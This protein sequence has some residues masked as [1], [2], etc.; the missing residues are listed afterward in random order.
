MARG[1]WGAPG[2]GSCFRLTLPRHPGIPI[3]SSPGPL[4]PSSVTAPKQIASGTMRT[5]DGGA[6]L[7]SGYPSTI[8]TKKATNA[9]PP[10]LEGEAV[11]RPRSDE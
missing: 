4:Q 1:G 9:L 8:G 3:A 5:S 7:V 11:A 6:R 10:T 2:E